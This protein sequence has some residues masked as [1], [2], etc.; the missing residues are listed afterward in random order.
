MSIQ[1]PWALLLLAAIPAVLFARRKFAARTGFSWLS[2]IGPDLAPGPVKTYGTDIIA[3]A[4]MALIVLAVANVQY[5]SFWQKRY[6]ESRWIMLVQDLSGS[7]GRPSDETDTTTLGDVA[8]DGARAFIDMRGKDDLIGII[9]FS[10]MAQLIA[11][12]SFDREILK[13][14]LELL[15][16]RE[17]SPVFRELTTGGETNASYATWLA[18][19]VF[20]MFLP[21]ENQPTYEQINDL[22]Y[23]LMGGSVNGVEIPDRLKRV[24]FGRGMAIVLFTDG[25]IEANKSA[26]DA[27]QGLLNFVK[28]IELVKRLGIRLYLIVVGGEVTGDVR[29]A[30]EG[31]DGGA[32]AGSIFYMPRSLDRE[33]ITSVYN[34]INEMEKNRLL[35][36]LEKRKRDTRWPLA[37][38]AACVLAA[39]CFLQSLPSIRKI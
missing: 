32:S 35:V 25:R 10:N 13:K 30:L 34:R 39:Y 12:P 24:D 19:C 9:A 28:V 5:S 14:K 18:L 20:F 23:S 3:A 37:L 27:S 7:M 22:R 2:L 16:R 8:L 29:M 21:E 38:A 33:K 15:N 26:E 6:L 11:P 36:R 4:A 1:Y 31:S 17:D